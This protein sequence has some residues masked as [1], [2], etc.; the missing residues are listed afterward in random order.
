MSNAAAT[1]AYIR[2]LSPERVSFVISGDHS[3]DYGDE[4]RACADYISS[5]LKDEQP[6]RQA[7]AARVRNSDAAIKFLN[8]DAPEFPAED[9]DDALCFDKFNFAMV[10]ERIGDLLTM[11]AI[12]QL[13]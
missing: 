9:L 4:D 6:N 2:T 13:L 12:P 10:V 5:L 7:I 1:A 8:P 11:S 3:A